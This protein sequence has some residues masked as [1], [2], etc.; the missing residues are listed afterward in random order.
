MG[1]MVKPVVL[2]NVTVKF[3]RGDWLDFERKCQERG[4][5]TSEVLRGLSSR[6]FRVPWVTHG[7]RVERSVWAR[8]AVVSGGRGLMGDRLRLLVRDWVRGEID[9]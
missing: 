2:E 4:V 5:S 9:L 7:F 6:E 8:F 3:S 1:S